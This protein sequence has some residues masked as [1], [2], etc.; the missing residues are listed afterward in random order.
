MHSATSAPSERVFKVSGSVQTKRRASIKA[1]SLRWIVMVHE[2][3]EWLEEV[4]L[5][6]LI[7]DD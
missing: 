4:E 2:N 6:E 5:E 3:L 1:D 7:F